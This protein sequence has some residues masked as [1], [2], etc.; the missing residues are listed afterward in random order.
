MRHDSKQAVHHTILGVQRLITTA[1][2]QALSTKDGVMNSRRRDNQYLMDAES[3]MI[4]SKV[5]TV[6][7]CCVL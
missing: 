5:R 4:G 3:I 7:V 6:V 1:V 2:N